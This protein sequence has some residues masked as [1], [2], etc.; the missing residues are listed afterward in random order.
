MLGNEARETEGEEKGQ[1]T[2]I[3]AD[4]AREQ[5]L[6]REDGVREIAVDEN[7][8]VIDEERTPDEQTQN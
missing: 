5:V 1:S 3:E 7:E 6:Q 2:I 8:P 4:G